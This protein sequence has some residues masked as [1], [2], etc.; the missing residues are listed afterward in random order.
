MV[1]A[2]VQR[3][4]LA[5]PDAKRADFE[6][7][8]A[9]INQALAVSPQY[10]LA[11][12]AKGQLFLAQRRCED[13]VPE[14][15]M[16]LAVDRNAVSALANLGWCK[17]LAGGSGDEAIQLIEQAIRL[18]PR[19]PSI[20]G[21]YYRIGLVHLLLSCTDQA[22]VWIEKARSTDPGSA[23][24][25]YFLAAAYGLKGELDR[26]AAELAEAQRLTGSDRY[27]TIARCRANGALNTQAV[28]D[29]FEGIFLAGLRKAGMPEE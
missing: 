20:A 21:R 27:S 7:A 2:L 16:A 23:A 28:S 10:P 13:A 29:R 3:G 14:F 19:D 18:S 26:A 8:E 17:F 1:S 24:P 4:L 9:L 5:T 25:H 22:I 11:H 15:E 6:R 12:E